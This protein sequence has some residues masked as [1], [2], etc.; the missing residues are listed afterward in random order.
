MSLRI[1]SISQN[2]YKPCFGKNADKAARI[3]TEGVGELTWPIAKHLE[4]LEGTRL[5]DKKPVPE[6]AVDYLKETL[7]FGP[8]HSVD[9]LSRY[10]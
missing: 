4:G 7:G 9:D 1:N 3:L 2:N 5:G 8:G 6:I 10:L